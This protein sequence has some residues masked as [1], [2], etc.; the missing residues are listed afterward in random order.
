MKN[1]L[2]NAFTLLVSFSLLF[3]VSCSKDDAADGPGYEFID[4][5][6][7]GMIDGISFTF[8]VGT[9]EVRND[10]EDLSVDFYD[11]TEE[12]T[13]VCGFFGFGDSVSVFFSIPN[14]VG[15]YELSF[16][17]DN[18]EDGR[19]VTMFNPAK[20][21]NILATEGAVEILSISDTEV[22]GRIDARAGDGD[23]INGNFTLT[24]CE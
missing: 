18:L 11:V 3:L 10:G 6:A 20:T 2:K 8:A 22:T 5:N 1:H 13:D 17:L 19:T 21:L 7:Q 4:Q 14:A 9:S 12:L 15:V 16:S 23:A 24:I